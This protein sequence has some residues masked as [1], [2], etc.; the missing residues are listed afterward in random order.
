MAYPLE[1]H[2]DRMLLSATIDPTPR[3][4]IPATTITHHID[5]YKEDTAICEVDVVP[6]E[7]SFPFHNVQTL[8]S[9]TK[10]SAYRKQLAVDTFMAMYVETRARTTEV[11]IQGSFIVASAEAE[12]G[13]GGCEV[14]VNMKYDI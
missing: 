12:N 4:G 7:L 9:V 11:K 8:L 13:H 10:R 1:V 5:K 2:D 6:A 14:W 3:Y